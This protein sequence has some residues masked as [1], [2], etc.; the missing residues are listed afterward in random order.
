ML[1]I[2]LENEGRSARLGLSSPPSEKSLAPL[3]QV[4]SAGKIKRVQAI[5][6]QNP[7]P[8]ATSDVF[9]AQVTHPASVLRPAK[10]SFR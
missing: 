2:H 3:E 7:L 8:A 9:G 10:I 6:G 1:T 5:N 4:T